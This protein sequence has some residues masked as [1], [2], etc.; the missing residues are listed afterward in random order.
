M[1]I[2]LSLSCRAG[3]EPV[4]CPGRGHRANSQREIVAGNRETSSNFCTQPQTHAFRSGSEPG[5]NVGAGSSCHPTVFTI[6]TRLAFLYILF[7]QDGPVAR[8]SGV[9]LGWVN[10]LTFPWSENRDQGYPPFRWESVGYTQFCQFIHATA[11]TV[12]K[13]S[14]AARQ[15]DRLDCCSH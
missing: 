9:F 13:W 6:I 1:E 12:R 7:G 11:D 14:Y 5:T 15:L 2:G 8:F 3:A 4:G 10:L